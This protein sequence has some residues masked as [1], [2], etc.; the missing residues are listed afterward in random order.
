VTGGGEAIDGVAQ[1]RQRRDVLAGRRSQHALLPERQRRGAAAHAREGERGHRQPVL[2]VLQREAPL[3]RQNAAVHREA[4][5][6][7]DQSNHA[8]ERAGREIDRL[9]GPPRGL[10]GERGERVARLEPQARGA[11]PQRLGAQ[12]AQPRRSPRP[13]VEGVERPRRD[14]G[15]L[16]AQ[17]EDGVAGVREAHPRLDLL[18]VVTRQRAG[19]QRRR[20]DDRIDTPPGERFDRRDE[21]RRVGRG[22]GDLQA[23]AVVAHRH[24]AVVVR[25]ARRQQGRGAP[26]H[27]IGDQIGAHRLEMTFEEQMQV[28]RHHP[29]ETHQ[30]PAEPAAGQALRL[31]RL[32][33]T[34]AADHPRL[35][36]QLAEQARAVTA[37]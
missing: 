23:A 33:E 9:L 27:E 22:Q 13:H 21:T 1:V 16:L 8:G 3:A 25:Q 10:E 11:A 6:A 37:A 19:E 31:Q 4:R 7:L 12:G 35:E 2:L 5:Q 24:H 17:H 29:P 26:L 20:A 15:G 18:G 34:L 28:R 30:V 32:G 36:Q 14:A